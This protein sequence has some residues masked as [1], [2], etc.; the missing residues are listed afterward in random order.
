LAWRAFTEPSPQLTEIDDR[1][2]PN[3]R[4]IIP[5]AGEEEPHMACAN[6]IRFTPNLVVGLTVTAAGAALLL[7][8]LDV[9]NARDL[10]RFWPAVLVLFGLSIIVQ[11]LQGGPAGAAQRPIITPGFVILLVLAGLFLSNFL[12]RFQ[13]STNGAAGSNNPAVY[14]VMSRSTRT[15]AAAPFR[16]ANMTTFMGRSRLDLSDAQLAPGEEAIVDVLGMMGAV[17]LVVPDGWDVQ[18]EAFP[19][20][21]RVAD[22][23]F[24]SSRT[25]TQPA[26]EARDTT[27][28]PG[29]TVAETDQAP[30]PSPA[31]AASAEPPRV[32]VRG[33]IMMGNLHIES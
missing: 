3:G 9:I 27:G 13:P 10:L 32:I 11:A 24:L 8:T 18:V 22:R 28:A 30:P 21:G 5:D 31:A 6:G 23:R 1:P 2:H 12:Q 4:Q 15:S 33:F 26:S 25:R 17:E 14:A 7:D 19:V 16:G 20:M 29:E